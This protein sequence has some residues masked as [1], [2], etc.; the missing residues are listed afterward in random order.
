[1]KISLQVVH[2]IAD[3]IIAIGAVVGIGL[4][5]IQYRE[6]A[7]LVTAARESFLAQ[8]FPVVKFSRYQ[9][10]SNMAEP[11]CDNPAH[12][13]NVYY[14]NMSGVPIAIEKADLKLAM[15]DRPILAG[16]AE[17]SVKIPG[18]A[19][20]APGTESAVGYSGGEFSSIYKR[21]LGPDSYPHLNLQLSLVYRSLSSGRKYKYMGSVV[22]LDDCRFSKQQWYT[23]SG[24]SANAIN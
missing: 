3:V 17:V 24:E 10:I 21:L 18:E 6:T 22:I 15:G 12:G 4:S 23:N 2:V 5:L 13:I 20:L 1:M 14:K 7:E 9:W 11:T 19:I 16:P 8:S